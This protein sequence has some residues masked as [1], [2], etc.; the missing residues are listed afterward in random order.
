MPAFTT[1][2]NN[3]PN[4]KGDT[5]VLDKQVYENQCAINM[6]A[7]LLRSGVNM[8]SFHGVRSWEKDK[9]KYA[10][11]AQEL[12]DWLAKQAPNLHAGFSKHSGKE[13]FDKIGKKQGMIFFQNYWGPGMQGDHI[14]LW[15]GVRL[16]TLSSWPRIHL[17][18]SG[19]GWSDF[20][21]SQSVWFWEL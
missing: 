13:V 9:P 3:H 16:T 1:L 15:N 17:H 18:L 14:D 8:N 11:R 21:K 5:P 6:S 10:I 4:I 20:R 19:G 7:A 12:A 2:W